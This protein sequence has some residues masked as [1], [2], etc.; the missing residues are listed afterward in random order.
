MYLLERVTVPVYG[1]YAG[2]QNQVS[3]EITR[4]SGED[5]VRLE[6][7]ITTAAYTDPTGVY[8]QPDVLVKRSAGSSLGFSFIYVKSAFGLTRS[9]WT[10]MVK[11]AGSLRGL[12]SS[13]SSAFVGDAFIIGDSTKPIVYR[14]GLDGT[15]SQMSLPPTG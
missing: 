7:D 3:M 5:P 6:V 10:P 15:F 2:Y 11:F 8:N 12:S 13:F 14:L 9:S 4:Q 1:L